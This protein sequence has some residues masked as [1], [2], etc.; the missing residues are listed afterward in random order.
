MPFTA[1]HAAAVLPFGS[2]L[3]ASALVIGAMLPDLPLFLPL[4]MGNTHTV[5][6][7]LTVNLVAGLV[8]FV[9]WHGFLARPLDWFAPSAIRRRLSP[10]QQPGLRRRL[11]SL[12]KI[13]VVVVSLLL[14]QATHLF[15]DLFTHPDTLVTARFEVFSAQV[16]GVPLYFLLQFGLSVVGLA[17]VGLWALRWYRTS[18]EYPLSRQPSRL[19]KIA[20]R[21]TVL[22]GS[23]AALLIAAYAAAG[24][25]A[26]TFLFRTSVAT[27]VAAGLC[28]V[29]VAAV[30][31]LRRS[32][33]AVG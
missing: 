4:P 15:L 28:G 25:D 3:S 33:Q 5:L 10:A 1:S 6:A 27:V 20:A 30:W 29:L 8:L 11:D 19:G 12:S 17:L 23:V 32:V 21:G 26:D 16:A 24:T 31:H 13:A 9:I 18:P 2:R 7:A 14:G 22:G